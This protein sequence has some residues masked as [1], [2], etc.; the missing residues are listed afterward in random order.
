[1][2]KIKGLSQFRSHN[3]PEP[4]TEYYSD[5]SSHPTS[6]LCPERSKLCE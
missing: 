3:N 4:K 5:S 6:V 1:M 2:V